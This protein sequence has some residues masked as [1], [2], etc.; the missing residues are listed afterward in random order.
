[1]TIIAWVDKLPL[2]MI[3]DSYLAIV[4][5]AQEGGSWTVFRQKESGRGKV[6]DKKN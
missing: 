3:L 1:M 6:I 5:A 2:E 4:F